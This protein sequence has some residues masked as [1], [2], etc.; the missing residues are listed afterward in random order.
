[1]ELSAL[2]SY[3]LV[4]N[5]ASI[6]IGYSIGSIPFGLLLTSIN[7]SIDIRNIGSGNIGAT[8]VLRTGNRKLALITLI[9]DAIKATIAV[10]IAS[11]LFNS[12]AGNIAGF[13]AFL[14]HIFPIWLKFKGG[15]GISTYVGFLIAFNPKIALFF[16][17][18]WIIFILIAHYSSLSSLAATSTIPIVLWITSQEISITL[19][20]TIMTVISYWKHIDNIKRLIAGVETK[21]ILKKSNSNEKQS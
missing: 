12:D 5:I 20:F 19:I 16:A 18:I 15:K 10:I 21:I 7:G 9:F 14:G 11:K 17:I 6:I 2:L 1:M 8:N 13:S 3:E 4:I